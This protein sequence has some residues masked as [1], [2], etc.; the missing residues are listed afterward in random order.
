[1]G[2]SWQGDARLAREAVSVPA[3]YQIL[4]RFSLGS[5][6]LRSRRK[7]NGLQRTRGPLEELVF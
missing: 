6:G 2:R 1:M 5:E 7:E 3:L 4:G